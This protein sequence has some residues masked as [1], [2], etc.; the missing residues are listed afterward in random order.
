[1]EHIQLTWVVF[2]ARAQR[3]IES[4]NAFQRQ[5]ELRNFGRLGGGSPEQSAILIRM[6]GYDFLEW[7]NSGA[8]RVWPVRNSPFA[9]EFCRPSYRRTTLMNDNC[10]DKFSHNGSLNYVWQRK[11]SS[12]IQRHTNI[13]ISPTCYRL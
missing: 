2:G 11:L 8:C 13:R 3:R 1:M 5:R 9:E 7:S 4:E 10:I 6:G 12:W